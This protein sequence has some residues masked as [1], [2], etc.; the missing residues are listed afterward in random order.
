MKR[1]AFSHPFFMLYDGKSLEN[2]IE[3]GYLRKPL[4]QVGRT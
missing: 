2:K 3:K 4:D 1:V